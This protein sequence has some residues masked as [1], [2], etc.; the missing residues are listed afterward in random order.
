MLPELCPHPVPGCASTRLAYAQTLVTGGVQEAG[1]GCTCPLP[2]SVLCVDGAA[3][4]NQRKGLLLRKPLSLG[5]RKCF[6]ALSFQDNL[7]LNAAERAQ[8]KAWQLQQTTA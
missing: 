3:Q 4:L 6:L 5:G 7:R 8:R 2:P 1:R